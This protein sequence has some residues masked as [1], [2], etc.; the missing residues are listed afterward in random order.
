M[1]DK[2]IAR[3][4]L[5]FQA[6]AQS[7]PLMKIPAYGAWSKRKLNEGVSAALISHL[8]ATSIVLLPEEVDKIM[9]NTFDEM[10]DELRFDE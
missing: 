10:L 2:E 8:D 9:E 5:D 6:R 7:Y 1:D 4:A 3:G